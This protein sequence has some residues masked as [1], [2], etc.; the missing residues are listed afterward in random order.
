MV[1]VLCSLQCVCLLHKH[2]P[3]FVSLFITSTPSTFASHEHEQNTAFNV[4]CWLEW[5]ELLQHHSYSLVLECQKEASQAGHL[6]Y[7]GRAP[8]TL[9][10][11]HDGHAEDR[12]NHGRG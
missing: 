5:P 10:H 1:D 12:E 9:G 2:N 8:V 3:K 4:L 6:M 11:Q 7:A